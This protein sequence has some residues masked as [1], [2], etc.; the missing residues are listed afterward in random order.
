MDVTDLAINKLIILYILNK[1]NKPSTNS[2]LTQIIL[3][4]NL[5]NYFTLQQYIS[6]LINT[7]FINT[8]TDNK[9]QYLVI[10]SKGSDTL[11]FFLNRI[12]DAKIEQLDDYFE[13]K[14]ESTQKIE[15]AAEYMPI[16]DGF[17]VNLILKKGAKNLIEIKLP[18]KTMEDIELI[19]TN[20]KNSGEDIYNNL[21]NLLN[22]K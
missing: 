16:K 5:I 21:T 3:E 7:G 4:N 17:E 19:R 20:W 1:L 22:K 11:N 14:N 18:V 12:P 13:N 9:K 15:P 6:E 8:I 2:Q 10:S